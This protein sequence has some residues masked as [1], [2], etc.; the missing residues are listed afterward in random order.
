MH[1]WS[2]PFILSSSVNVQAWHILKYMILQ[3]IHKLIVVHMGHILVELLCSVL[4]SKPSCIRYIWLRNISF[5]YF[6]SLIFN[7]QKRTRIISQ[8]WITIL[9][10]NAAVFWEYFGFHI[11]IIFSSQVYFR[12]TIKSTIF[13]LR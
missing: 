7:C 1:F 9:E 3:G 10:S 4:Y 8:Q 13:N 11:S 6:S 12:F 2:K 5:R